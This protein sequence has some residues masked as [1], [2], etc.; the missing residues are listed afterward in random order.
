MCRYIVFLLITGIVWAQTHYD[1]KGWISKDIPADLDKLILKNGIE[2]IGE[3]SRTDFRLYRYNSDDT[4]QDIIYFKPLDA[5]AFQPVPVQIIKVLQLKD[6]T[7]LYNTERKIM[8][9]EEKLLLTTF[10]IT[11][12]GIYLYNRYSNLSKGF[13][14][15]PIPLP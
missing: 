13:F 11:L 12:I 2:Y 15:D 5:N 1:S 7:L 4:G 8:Y 14:D 3:Y 10:G 9:N 6:G